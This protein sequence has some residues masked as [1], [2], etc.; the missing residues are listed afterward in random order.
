[1]TIEL[2]KDDLFHSIYNA[3]N[4][5][6]DISKHPIYDGIQFNGKKCKRY[7]SMKSVTHYGLYYNNTILYKKKTWQNSEASGTVCIWGGRGRGQWSPRIF[8]YYYFH[9]D[10]SC[11]SFDAAATIVLYDWCIGFISFA[12]LFETFPNMLTI[13]WNIW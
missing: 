8:M 6:T 2:C 13:S 1:M 11:L 7:F 3:I 5:L 9:G 4:G 10:T 12:F